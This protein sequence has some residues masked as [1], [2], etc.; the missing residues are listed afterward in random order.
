MYRVFT[1]FFIS[2]SNRGRIIGAS[3]KR[4]K[5][6]ENGTRHDELLVTNV[7]IGEVENIIINGTDV[8]EVYAGS[9]YGGKNGRWKAYDGSQRR[10]TPIIAGYKLPGT[11]VVEGGLNFTLPN[12]K[13]TGY[14]KNIQF[15]DVH[16][17][18]KGGN[19]PSD[20]AAIPPEL[21]VGQYNASNLKVQPSYGLWARHVMGLSI[22]QSSF[23]YEQP[24]GRYVL[25]FDDV[26]G[27]TIAGTKMIKAKDNN[28][29]IKLKNSTGVAVENIAY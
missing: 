14:I 12:G 11:G 17:L 2:I 25:F 4:F 29:E 18:V 23:N 16:F 7:N 1:P 21:G 9:S 15:K 5:F 24:D 27:A 20:T 6:D 10:A 19:P 3:V 8:S 13:H 26:Q 28:T 22:Q